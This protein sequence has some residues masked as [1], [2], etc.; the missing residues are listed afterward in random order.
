MSQQY[1]VTGN[2]FLID[3]RGSLREGS[4]QAFDRDLPSRER[5]AAAGPQVLGDAPI[6]EG[7]FQISYTLEQFLMGDAVPQ[8][9]SLPEKKADLSFRVFNRTGQ[10]LA[11]RSIEALDRE[12]GPEETIFNAP[13]ELEVN[14]HVVSTR[15]LANSE[16]EQ[17]M[18]MIAPVIEDVPL[19]EL[20]NEDMVFL[21]NELGLEQ[22]G[23]E[24]QRIALLRG[25]ALLAAGMGLPTEAFYG[26][27]RTGLPDLWAELQ[28]LD[29][30]EGHRGEV[31]TRL[32][33]HLAAT[34]EDVLVAH[35]LRAVEDRITPAYIRERASAIAHAIRR[36]AQ[37]ELVV[38]LR[39]G[40]EP[41]GEALAGYAVTALDPDANDRDLGTDVTDTLGELSIQYFVD[42][43]A[44]DAERSLRFRVRGPAIAEA[45]DV[46]KQFRPNADAPT[47]ISVTLPAT[48]PTLR[49]LRD[50]GHLDVPDAV[51]E[52]LEQ[53]TVGIRSLA[54]IRRSGGLRSI[55]GLD[56]LDSGV[57]GRLEALAYLDLLSS[58]PNETSALLE[59]RYE[60]VATIAETPRSEFVAAMSAD[61]AGF[62][63]ARATEL[64]IMA[65]AQIDILGQIFAGIAA[66]AANGFE[67]PPGSA[68]GLDA[69]FLR[70]FIGER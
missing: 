58:D 9:R 54:D 1:L 21:I 62:S 67:A 22:Q 55:A 3:D 15:E 19:I 37:K 70:P 35:L 50:D 36:R 23:E 16:Y 47:S 26:W 31:I 41:T 52:T 27:A 43:A 45:I 14:I 28:V 68:S 42:A 48:D 5:R 49:Q 2:V 69:S 10:E 40:R 24:Q 30:D 44:G 8:G 64:H 57:I 25:S 13:S 11:I 34:E 60:S 63:G 32:L 56:E 66:D 18:A 6:A 4:V 53:P 33:D 59:Q 17:L 29:D 51:L 65:K 39:L 12:F 20:S 7:R 46:T 61:G 38:R